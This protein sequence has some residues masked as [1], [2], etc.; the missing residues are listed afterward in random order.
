[1]EGS[2]Q[3][4]D[5]TL[6]E[7]LEWKGY[8]LSSMVIGLTDDKGGTSSE[9]TTQTSKVRVRVEKPVELSSSQ[10]GRHIF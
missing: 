10:G 5:S 8:D 7:E 4:M 1:M 3:M 6:S 2:Q 9:F